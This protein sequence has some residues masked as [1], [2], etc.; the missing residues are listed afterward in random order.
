MRTLTSEAS[1][2][3]RQMSAEEKAPFKDQSAKLTSAYFAKLPP[4]PPRTRKKGVPADHLDHEQPRN[5]A[6]ATPGS[7]V[8]ALIEEQPSFP[9][10]SDAIPDGLSILELGDIT[11]DNSY[12]EEVRTLAIA[13]STIL[14]VLRHKY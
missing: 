6:G 14:C 9:A 3:W 11:V 12:H 5:S 10:A 7:Q 13:L 4:K 1:T 2:L 8:P